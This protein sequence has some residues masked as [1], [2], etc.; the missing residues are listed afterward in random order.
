[1]IRE[2]QP[3]ALV[4]DRLGKGERGVNPLCD[5]YTREQPSEMNV[6][7]PF[8]R[9]QPYSWEACMTIGE[10]WQYSIKD[11]QL[12]SAREL[13]RILVDVVSRGGN[14][15]LNVGP[16]PDGEIPEP[17]VERL[18][19]VGAWLQVNGESIYGTT[20]SPFTALPA[21]KCTARGSRIYV[22]LEKHPGG[23]VQLPRLQN[24]IRKAWLLKTGAELK[25]DN[26]AKTIALPDELPDDDM[27]T[28]AV[29]LDAPP[30][31]R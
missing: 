21:G 22:H 27:T 16:T 6:A 5:F 25:F 2:L 8:E 19:G 13:I 31:V 14:L 23:P 12:K 28:I 17:L 29:E 15:L 9:Q 1:M 4:N 11:K 7:M 3:A 24:T 26:A 18:R 10:Y 30:V 20:R